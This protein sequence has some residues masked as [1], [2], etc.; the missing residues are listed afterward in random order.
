A[1]YPAALAGSTRP[2]RTSAGGPG[3]QFAAISRIAS[4]LRI[5]GNVFGDTTRVVQVAAGSQAQCH[6]ARQARLHR[7]VEYR[8]YHAL[9]KRHN[10]AGPPL[11]R[12]R[13]RGPRSS[14]VKY[15][16]G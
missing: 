2:Q 1:L 7:I 15:P 9:A 4:L 13:G 8:L 16:D 11:D 14:T 10:N 12:S 5:G 6:T 3:L